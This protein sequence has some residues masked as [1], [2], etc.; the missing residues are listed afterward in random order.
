MSKSGKGRTS[1]PDPSEGV[2][3]HPGRK[4]SFEKAEAK[5]REVLRERGFNE[6]MIEAEL[7]RARRRD[8]LD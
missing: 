4:K 3:A 2:V 8:L 1:G 6:E 7:K 5:A